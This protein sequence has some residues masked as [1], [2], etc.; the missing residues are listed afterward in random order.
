MKATS[1][2][3]YKNIEVNNI[4]SHIGIPSMLSS[5]NNNGTTIVD[6]LH[7]RYKHTEVDTLIST[8]YAK[9]ETDNMLNQEVNTSGGNVM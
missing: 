3:T 2:S 7:S 8:S 9:S 4:I 6:I 1:L 5:I